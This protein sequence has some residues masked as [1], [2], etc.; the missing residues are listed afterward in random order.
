MI[1]SKKYN[2]NAFSKGSIQELEYIYNEYSDMIYH[3]CRQYIT[4]DEIAQEIVQDTFIKLWEVKDG[5]IA[6]LS[7]KNYLYTIAKNNCLMHLRK[8]K[9]I[10]ESTDRLNYLEARFNYEV[11][12]NMADTVIEFD[13]LK[14]KVE[15]AINEL[16]ESLKQV[17]LLSRIEELK[18]KEIAEQL[19]ISMK[20]VEARMSKALKILRSELQDYLPILYLISSLL[21]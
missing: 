4:E 10:I 3:L 9:N 15:E 16:P 2:I 14:N 13:E 18:Y 6:E 19:D 21:Y 17:F 12:C 7:I 1:N 20:T 5:L 11:L 8:R